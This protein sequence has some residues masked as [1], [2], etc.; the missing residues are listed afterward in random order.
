MSWMLHCFCSTMK[1]ECSTELVRGELKQ[2]KRDYGNSLATSSNKNF[3][4]H[5]EL[6]MFNTLRTGDADLRF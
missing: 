3:T 1:M 5:Y 2:P 4:I 6:Q